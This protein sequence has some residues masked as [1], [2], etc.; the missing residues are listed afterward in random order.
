MIEKK[1]E[2][3]IFNGQQ[4]FYSHHSDT[5]NC[6]MEFSI[7]LPPQ[8][9]NKKCPVLYWLSGLTC[10]A[11]NFTTKSGFQRY[12][13]EHGVIVVAPDTSPR[14]EQVKDIKDEWDIGCG[15]G[16]YVN[17]TTNE[18]NQHFKMYDYITKELPTLIKE[19]FSCS[20]KASISGHS[21]GGHGALIC[22]LKNP[23]MYQATSAFSPIVNPVNCPWGQKAFKTYLG[24]DNES[25]SAWDSVELIKQ[26]HQV[27]HL[28]VDQGLADNF[29]DN[30]IK[31]D[32]LKQA[33]ESKQINLDLKYRE[34]YDHSYY[35]I[36]SFIGEHIKWH[37]QFLD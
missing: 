34:G 36:S 24:E 17:A 12:A 13:A 1:S 15:A 29:L 22:S 23:E 5:L 4:F 25:W 11:E 10:T 30:Q 32:A 28:F 26:G 27:K 35:Y 37:A 9:K 21:M 3:L 7:Y 33:C 16:F 20:D 18:W 6:D 8:S 19:N 14:G 31:T 2:N